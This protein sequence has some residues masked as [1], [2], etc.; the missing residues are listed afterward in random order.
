MNRFDGYWGEAAKVEQIVFR[1]IESPATRLAE[2]EAGSID[3]ALNLSPEDYDTVD[4]SPDLKPVFAEANLSVGYIGMHQGNEPF[5]DV[6]V[7]QALAYA[8]DKQAVVDAF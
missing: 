7:R 1:G 4:T 6:R 5:G 3:M 2:L 8:V